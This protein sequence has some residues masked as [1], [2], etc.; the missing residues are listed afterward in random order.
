[1]CISKGVA[2]ALGLTWTPGIQLAGVGGLGGA[3]GLADQEI[4]LRIGGDGRD[5]DVTSTPFQGSFCIKVQPVIMTED[6]ARTIG[7]SALIGMS[8]CGVQTLALTPT[9]RPWKSP[10]LCWH[11]GVRVSKFRSRAS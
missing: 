3:E 10:P 8:V 4:V 6:L 11:M 7:H 5:D 9:R 1:M 2:N